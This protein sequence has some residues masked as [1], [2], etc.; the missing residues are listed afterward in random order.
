MAKCLEC[1]DITKRPK[2]VIVSKVGAKFNKPEKVET[3]QTVLK[4]E[5]AKR[6][7][8]PRVK[9]EE[10]QQEILSSINNEEA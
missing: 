6:S 9:V 7:Y 5:P 2:G 10:E 8:V 3:P 1:S 4:S